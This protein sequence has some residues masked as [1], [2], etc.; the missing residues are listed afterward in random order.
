MLTLTVSL[1]LTLSLTLGA[2]AERG[3]TNAPGEVAATL[4]RLPV[5]RLGL[6]LGLGAP[7]AAIIPTTPITVQLTVL[8]TMLPPI[9]LQVLRLLRATAAQLRSASAA[10]LQ[11]LTLEG[12]SEQ[13]APPLR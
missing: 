6:G 13:Q 9:L 2:D 1:A 5:L 12:C 10:S 4:A 8:L 7:P 3:L 11:P